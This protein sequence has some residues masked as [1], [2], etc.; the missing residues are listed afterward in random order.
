MSA[1]GWNFDDLNVT[2]KND[3]Q[4]FRGLLIKDGWVGGEVGTTAGV[5]KASAAVVVIQS[6]VLNICGRLVNPGNTTLN[7]TTTGHSAFRVRARINLTGPNADGNLNQVAFVIDYPE[8]AAPTQQDINASGTIYDCILATGVI[9]GGEIASVKQAL[10]NIR[11]KHYA[12]MKKGT[13]QQIGT[14]DTKVTFSAL[15]S[16]HVTI[17]DNQIYCPIGKSLALVNFSM[18]FQ[19]EQDDFGWVSAWVELNGTPVACLKDLQPLTIG[20]PAFTHGSALIEVNEGNWLQV[21]AKKGTDLG[22]VMNIIANSQISV[23]FY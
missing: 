7:V 15:T 6:G 1:T 22:A 2:A 10:G 16:P 13:A 21:V 14:S 8:Y 3:G 19:P 17:N 4:Y 9:A 5:L 11:D 18:G 23:E 20:R 12:I